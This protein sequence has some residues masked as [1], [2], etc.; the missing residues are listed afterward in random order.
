MTRARRI[1]EGE[2]THAERGT[3]RDSVLTDVEI[4]PSS[5]EP[6]AKGFCKRCESAADNSSVTRGKDGELVGFTSPYSVVVAPTGMAH[7]DA[8]EGL[9]LCGRE[10]GDW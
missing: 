2:R 5:H 7:F 4:G 3:I 1:S 6:L 8:G 9:T 10:H